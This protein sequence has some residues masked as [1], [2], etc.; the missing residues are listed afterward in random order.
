VPNT[1]ENSTPQGARALSDIARACGL[2][3]STISRALRGHAKVSAATRHRIE[4]VAERLGY[5]PNPYIAALMSNVR[6][7]RRATAAA[8]ALARIDT[9][10]NADEWK[11][12][13]VQSQFYIGAL[14]RAE[15]LGHRLERFH[16]GNSNISPARLT[17]ILRARGI[18]GVIC[19]GHRY[20]AHGTAFPFDRD[21]F[22]L[23]TVGFRRLEG[24][25]FVQH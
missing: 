22:A 9:S 16:G 14:A 12:D 1:P 10:P 3:I 11:A 13:P 4:E 24:G 21:R 19:S 23:V 20:N 8:A 25:H 5:R 6:R 7:A 15:R 17:G 2:S 18:T